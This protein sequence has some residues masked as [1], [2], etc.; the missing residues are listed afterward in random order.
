MEDQAKGLKIKRKIKGEIVQY[1][2]STYP[3]VFTSH[4]TWEGVVAILP[5]LGDEAVVHRCF[6]SSGNSFRFSLLRTNKTNETLST[7]LKLRLEGIYARQFGLNIPSREEP[8]LAFF[9]ENLVKTHEVEGELEETPECPLAFV[10]FSRANTPDWAD[11]EMH[12]LFE[13]TGHWEES[14]C[15]DR[16]VIEGWSHF[17]RRPYSNWKVSEGEEPPGAY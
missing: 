3:L 17:W 1:F 5:K 4:I 15:G 14:Y 2:C 7:S 13:Y 6:K 11:Y 12:N 10:D 8:F 16:F 9:T